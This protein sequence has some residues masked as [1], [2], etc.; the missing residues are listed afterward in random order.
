MWTQEG[1]FDI[2]SCVLDFELEVVMAVSANDKFDELPPERRER[3]LTI[4]ERMRREHPFM[5]VGE[6]VEHLRG[7]D[8]DAKVVTLGFFGESFYFTLD[9][10]QCMESL[11]VI[12]QFDVGP[13][14]D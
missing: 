10:F 7:M 6:L 12:E 2:I 9:R 11:L 1:E 3:I 8:P 4:S 5:T 13:E 14:P